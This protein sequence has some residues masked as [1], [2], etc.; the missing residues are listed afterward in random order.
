MGFFDKLLDAAKAIDNLA[1]K[2]QAEQRDTNNNSN[3][4]KAQT[5]SKPEHPAPNITRKT[6]QKVLTT[7]SQPAKPLKTFSGKQFFT[8][9]DDKDYVVDYEIT[10]PGDFIDFDCGAG[11]I[12]V[13]FVYLPGGEDDYDES[14]LNVP[15]I[16]MYTSLERKTQL[17]IEQC[18]QGKSPEDVLMYLAKDGKNYAYKAKLRVFGKIFYILGDV[19]QDSRIV[20]E[21]HIVASYNG[22]VLGTPLESKLIA[23]AECVADSYRETSISQE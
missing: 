5:A 4:S 13:S 8:G 3:G 6:D 15:S 7:G 23:A 12:E 10:I 14:D 2:M 1:E 21:K 16:S 19:K 9:T 11:E 20:Y 22:D 18:K 17:L